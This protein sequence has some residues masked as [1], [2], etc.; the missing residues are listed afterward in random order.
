[1]REGVDMALSVAGGWRHSASGSRWRG[2]S[3][4]RD[5]TSA[6]GDFSFFFCLKPKTKVKNWHQSEQFCVL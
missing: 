2:V 4:T 1:M 3:V 5:E 6:E